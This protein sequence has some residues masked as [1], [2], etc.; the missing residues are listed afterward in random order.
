M[1]KKKKLKKKD[2]EI[3]NA[4]LYAIGENLAVIKES[5]SVIAWAIEDMRKKDLIPQTEDASVPY[6]LGKS[7][8]KQSS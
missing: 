6:N 3:T 7:Y 2:V 8:G 4:L 5:V 1:G